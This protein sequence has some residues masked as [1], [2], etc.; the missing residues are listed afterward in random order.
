LLKNSFGNTYVVG[1]TSCC[2][3]IV[4]RFY[5]LLPG[6]SPILAL[7]LCHGTR[8]YL[9]ELMAAVMWYLSFNSHTMKLILFRLRRCGGSAKSRPA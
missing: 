2:N 5:L 6:E 4:L 3:E 8:R 7:Q 1:S 9:G